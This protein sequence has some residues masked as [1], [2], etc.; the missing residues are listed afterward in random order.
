MNNTIKLLDLGKKSYG[1]TFRLQLE[2]L[3]NRING[4]ISDTLLFVEHHPVITMGR[5]GVY[6]NLLLSPDS[7]KE[8]NIELFET[9]RGGDITCHCPGQLVAYPILDL[10]GHGSDLHIVIRKYEEVIIRALSRYGLETHTIEGL[11][12][13]WAGRDKIAAIGVGVKRWV[14]FHGFALNVN[15]DLTPYSYIVPCGIADKGVTNMKTLLGYEI[16]M[17]EIK[18]SVAECFAEVFE[19]HLAAGM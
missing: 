3:E 2:L 5:A 8:K 7:L 12:G 9:N 19:V 17:F 13:V 6:E 4:A 18:K 1:D 15:N 16:D 14:S 10:T 11:T